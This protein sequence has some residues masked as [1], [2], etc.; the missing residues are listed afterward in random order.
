MV[1]SRFYWSSVV[2]REVVL[3]RGAV[4][5]TLLA[6]VVDLQG[7]G[8]LDCR[9]ADVTYSTPRSFGLLPWSSKERYNM[10]TGL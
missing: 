10:E 1:V 8:D 2:F 4:L 6:P 7:L 9:T 5:E 3:G